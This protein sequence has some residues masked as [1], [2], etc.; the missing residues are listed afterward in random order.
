MKLCS[1]WYALRLAFVEFERNGNA[2]MA[3]LGHDVF[4]ECI[5]RMAALA[6]RAPEHRVFHPGRWKERAAFKGDVAALLD[7]RMDN[8]DAESCGDELAHHFGVVALELKLAGDRKA[9]ENLI[10]PLPEQ[11]F[12]TSRN[13]R[14]F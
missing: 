2:E 7:E 10:N 13:E 5:R 12:A 9:V 3:R 8:R 1:F 6:A 14:V 11:C 4:G